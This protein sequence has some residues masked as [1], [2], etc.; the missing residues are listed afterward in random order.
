ME[1]ACQGT[2]EEWFAAAIT[3]A[4]TEVL[5]WWNK[6]PGLGSVMADFLKVALTLMPEEDDLCAMLREELDGGMTIGDKTALRWLW[7]NTEL[8]KTREWMMLLVLG[9]VGKFWHPCVQRPEVSHEVA[10]DLA[11]TLHGEVQEWNTMAL[12]ILQSQDDPA[13]ASDDSDESEWIRVESQ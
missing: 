13:D 5:A 9:P 11:M 6:A 10:M 1:E 7:V 2:T 12:N 4:P 3:N 8:I